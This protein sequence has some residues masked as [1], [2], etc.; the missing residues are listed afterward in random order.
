MSDGERVTGSYGYL[1]P[2]GLYRHVEYI[3][4]EN[5]FRAKIRTSEPGTA[6]DNPSNIQ[7]ESNP[8]LVVSPPASVGPIASPITPSYGD[9]STNPSPGLGYRRDGLRPPPNRLPNSNPNRSTLPNPSPIPR[10]PDQSRNPNPSPHINGNRYESNRSPGE[11]PPQPVKP[12][13][14]D[15]SLRPSEVESPR[16]PSVSTPNRATF[17]DIP[18]NVM[19]YR[20]VSPKKPTADSPVGDVP[21]FDKPSD[22]PSNRNEDPIRPPYVRPPYN[23]RDPHSGRPLTSHNDKPRQ[24]IPSE[25]DRRP[26]L[27]DRRYE[28]STKGR[29]NKMIHDMGFIEA[30]KGLAPQSLHLCPFSNSQPQRSKQSVPS[31]RQFK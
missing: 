26:G 30:T 29:P 13:F 25:D 6:N 1:G 2:D 28:V 9:V 5:G 27:N 4:D 22:I 16:N 31:C 7:I 11:P 10:P 21:Q 20:G 23:V 15:P 18:N 19:P 24:P 8:I 3:A 12:N 14:E 17:A